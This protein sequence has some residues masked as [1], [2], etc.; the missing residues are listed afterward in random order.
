MLSSLTIVLL[1]YCQVSRH[2][3]C[4]NVLLISFTTVLFFTVKS[5]NCDV[6]L[7]SRFTTVLFFCCQVLRLSCL[8]SSSKIVLLFYCQVVR[9][10]CCSTVKSHDFVVVLLSSHMTLLLFYC[11]VVRQTQNSF[12]LER[13]FQ[14]FKVEESQW[15]TNC[16]VIDSIERTGCLYHNLVL[17]NCTIQSTQAYCTVYCIT[18]S[19]KTNYWTAMNEK[20][21]NTR[22]FILYSGTLYLPAARVYPPT[23]VTTS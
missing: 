16:I 7:L 20:W 17:K 13:Y 10:R 6:V 2:C 15:W 11:Q 14:S 4:S 12:K 1:F 22:L 9:L 3:Y 18:S 8:L 19:M 5:Y 21:C 23:H